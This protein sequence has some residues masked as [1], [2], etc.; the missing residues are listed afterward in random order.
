MVL[1]NI[2]LGIKTAETSSEH[3][4]GSDVVVAWNNT[5][6]PTALVKMHRTF[7]LGMRI[8]L[9][10]IEEVASLFPVNSDRNKLRRI[11]EMRMESV[12]EDNLC[13]QPQFSKHNLPR[14]KGSPFLEERDLVYVVQFSP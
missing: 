14:V 13:L 11:F 12:E 9:L 5:F 3:F 2:G 10:H 7:R 4:D 6:T 8:P 1:E